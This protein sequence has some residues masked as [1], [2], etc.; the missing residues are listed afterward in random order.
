M[1]L[2]EILI[3]GMVATL[4]M[5]L[6]QRLLPSMT[7]RP[8]GGWAV[9]GRWVAGFRRGAFISPSIAAEPSVR[10][11]LAIGWAFHYVVGFAYAA[12][13]VALVEAHVVSPTF[14][15]AIIFSL[16]LLVAPWLVM[17]PALGQGFLALRTPKPAVVRAT[18]VSVHFV[19]GLGLYLGVV[20]WRTLSE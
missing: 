12:A 15:S 6:W 17:Q 1:V 18:N 9:V 14:L 20:I 7:G 10:G 3:V 5:D 2:A 19:F 13:Y 4:A 8:L 16:A 11:E